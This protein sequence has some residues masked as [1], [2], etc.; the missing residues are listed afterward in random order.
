MEKNEIV[1]V[2]ISDTHTHT[3]NLKLPEGDVLIHAGDFT[4]TGT[5]KEVSDFNDFLG[6]QNFKYKIVISGNHELTFDLDNYEYLAKLKKQHYKH[7]NA[8]EIKKSLTNCIYLEDS[9]CEVF[10]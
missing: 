8:S 6:K 2:C 10:G 1:F 4:Y 9:A 3:K 7:Y 5:P